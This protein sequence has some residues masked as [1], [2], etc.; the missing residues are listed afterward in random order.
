MLVVASESIPIIDLAIAA[1]LALLPLLEAFSVRRISIKFSTCAAKLGA[2][3]LFLDLLRLGDTC[4]PL[5]LF[6]RLEAGWRGVSSRG[7]GPVGQTSGLIFS[8]CD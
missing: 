1:G 4:F 6:V 5:P 2:T 3:W 8:T 7:A